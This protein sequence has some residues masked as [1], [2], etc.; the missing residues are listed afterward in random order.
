MSR[1]SPTARAAAA[2]G[3]ALLWCVAGGS[4]A[5]APGPNRALVLTPQKSGTLSNLIGVSP[6]NDRVVWASGRGGA[7]ALTTD[8]GAHWRSGVVAGAEAL[9][10][11]DVEAFSADVAYL[12]AIGNGPDS[13]IYKTSD[14]G[15]SW[16]QQ[17]I[18]HDSKAF[19]NCFS[20]WS[21]SRGIA[22]SDSVDGHFP[23]LRTTDGKT[24]VEIG[25]R[26]PAARATEGG[27][28]SSGTCVA[29]HGA[30]H[31]WIA[32]GA[33]APRARVL[34][35]E[36]GGDHWTAHETPLRGAATAGAFSVAFRDPLHGLVGG[37]ELGPAQADLDNVARSSDGGKTWKLT[38]RAPIGTIFGLAYAR[39]RAA[40][41]VAHAIVVATGP[42]GAAWSA[43][44]GDTWTQLPG[45]AHY[46][47]VAFADERNGWL[48]G[49]EGRILKIEVTGP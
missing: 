18:G 27:F 17:F 3:A 35:T 26:L 16:A 46:W 11:R 40:A 28:S 5:N 9:Q 6:V 30:R 4:F 45:V 19:Y 31:G 23:G 1:L 20:F 15:K 12:L 49:T 25:Q 13:R 42:G 10:F 32:T 2:A 8:G 41:P 14:G 44:E 22:F 36:D 34:V 38:A 24:W 29:T 43:D 37:G 48:V 7:F 33:S 21:E 47:S 39:P